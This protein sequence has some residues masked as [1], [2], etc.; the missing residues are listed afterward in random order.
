MPGIFRYPARVKPDRTS[1]ALLTHADLAPILL[2]PCGLP[3][4]GI[5]LGTTERGPDLALFRIFG[6]YCDL[7]DDPYEMKNLADGCRIELESCS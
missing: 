3:I 1:E 4:S 5:L 7:A 2:S 6:P